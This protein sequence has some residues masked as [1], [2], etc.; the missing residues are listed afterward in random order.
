MLEAV[1]DDEELDGVDFSSEEG[2]KKLEQK[3][4]EK[5]ADVL[6]AELDAILTSERNRLIA[7][8]KIKGFD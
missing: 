5:M 7:I 3:Y 1:G 6:V 8:I 4:Q 2:H